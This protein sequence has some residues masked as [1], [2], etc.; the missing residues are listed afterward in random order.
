MKNPELLA[1]LK[2]LR[3]DL[4][5]QT[6]E[7]KAIRGYLNQQGDQ[8]QTLYN[9]YLQKLDHEKESYDNHT[10]ALKEHENALKDGR[11]L[12]VILLGGIALAIIIH[13]LLTR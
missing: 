13:A 7:L 3:E 6:A 9:L 12:L 4:R 1:E 11:I 5:T 8:V 2:A 10:S